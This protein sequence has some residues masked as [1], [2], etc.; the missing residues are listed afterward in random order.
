M[1]RK[2]AAIL[3]KEQDEDLTRAENEKVELQRQQ[4]EAL[5]M[6]ARARGKEEEDAE[7]NKR[8][9]EQEGRKRDLEQ[10]EYV[11]EMAANALLQKEKQI[12][13]AANERERKEKELESNAQLQRQLKL[14]QEHK[15]EI[16]PLADIFNLSQQATLDG[17]P[18]TNPLTPRKEED[19]RAVLLRFA[20]PSWV[21]ALPTSPSPQSPP[22]AWYDPVPK[23]TDYRR[24]S[25]IDE[26][27]T[28]LHKCLV[29]GEMFLLMTTLDRH[30][31]ELHRPAITTPGRLSKGALQ[32]RASFYEVP[33]DRAPTPPIS[34]P[35][36]EWDS[37]DVIEMGRSTLMYSDHLSQGALFNV[38]MSEPSRR[39]LS[40]TSSFSSIGK[41]I[42][43]T[44]SPPNFTVF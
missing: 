37:G 1:E 27:E 25:V 5:E 14:E 30:V 20:V 24:T 3:K 15:K 7:R 17:A 35:P 10:A 28:V 4:N 41:F 43:F 8:E 12:Q 16:M 38:P 21:P 29:C 42:L 26:T 11:K 40:R 44:R 36:V 39:T 2:K 31:S 34:T 18:G 19:A 22:T 6:K 9:V 23:S 33:L 13:E 32:R